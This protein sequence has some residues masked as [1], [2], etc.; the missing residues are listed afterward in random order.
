[1]VQVCLVWSAVDVILDGTLQSELFPNGGFEIHENQEWTS[2]PCDDV[3]ILGRGDMQNC[4]L[5]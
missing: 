1:M 2:L 4:G 3:G 5:P